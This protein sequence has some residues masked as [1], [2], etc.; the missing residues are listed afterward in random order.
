MYIPVLPSLK[1][2]TNKV[3]SLSNLADT[4]PNTHHVRFDKTI[5]VVLVPCRKEYFENGLD[6]LL[7]WKS[8]DYSKFRSDMVSE[9]DASSNG[10]YDMESQHQLVSET[11][12]GHTTQTIVSSRSLENLKQKTNILS[13]METCINMHFTHW[14]NAKN[15]IQQNSFTSN[16]RNCKDN[17]V[18]PLALIAS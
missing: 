7:W 3:D 11:G 10:N 4:Q 15:K 18:H 12:I 16:N 13:S 9:L 5:R 8:D 6:E 14:N 17:F 1:S 2:E